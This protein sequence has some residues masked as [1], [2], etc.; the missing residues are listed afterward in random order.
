MN[1][2]PEARISIIE[3]RSVDA[4]KSI[5]VVSLLEATTYPTQPRQHFQLLAGFLPSGKLSNLLL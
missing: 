5:D 1:E 3:A 4:S 2:H